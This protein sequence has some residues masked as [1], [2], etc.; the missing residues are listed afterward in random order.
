VFEN[1]VRR[2]IAVLE[3]T[4]VLREVEDDASRYIAL[5]EP[6]EDLVDRRQRLQLDIGLDRAVD[7][8]GERFGHVLGVCQQKNPW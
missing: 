6:V 3:P 8:E 4:E 1:D 7:S 2:F 5:L